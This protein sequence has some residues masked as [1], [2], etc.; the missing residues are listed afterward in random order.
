MG[1]V[2]S[3]SYQA[4]GLL[5]HSTETGIAMLDEMMTINGYPAL[6]RQRHIRRNSIWS[7]LLQTRIQ[8][9]IN[10]PDAKEKEISGQGDNEAMIRKL[11]E[12]FP[13]S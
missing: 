4:L 12:I 9:A 8:A 1:E 7:K 10:N 5:S 2:T 6:C 3:P 13:R 11:M